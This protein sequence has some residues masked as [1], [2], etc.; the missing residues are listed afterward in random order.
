MTRITCDSKVGNS[1]DK[2]VI[3]IAMMSV[4]MTPKTDEVVHTMQDNSKEN[5][6]SNRI[7]T[8]GEAKQVE[9]IKRNS[10]Q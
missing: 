10:G 5:S 8:I 7:V 6:V 4:V 3:V 9:T 1:I 2:I